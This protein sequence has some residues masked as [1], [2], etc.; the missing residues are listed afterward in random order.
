LSENGSQNNLT[1]LN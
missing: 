1:K